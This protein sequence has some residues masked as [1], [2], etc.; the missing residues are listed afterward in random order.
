LRAVE[1]KEKYGTLRF[2]VGPAPD[3]VF[4]LIAFAESVLASVRP[5]EIAEK[6]GY[7]QAQNIVRCMCS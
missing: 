7:W 5:V 3:T 4:A 2:Y 1:V 6:P